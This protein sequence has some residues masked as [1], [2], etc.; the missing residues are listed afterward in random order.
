MKLH[1][2]LTTF[3]IASCDTVIPR[4]NPDYVDG[5]V[6]KEASERLAEDLR[7][8]S[9]IQELEASL[10]YVKIRLRIYDAKEDGT[11]DQD[12]AACKKYAEIVAR[13]FVHLSYSGVGSSPICQ[14]TGL[15]YDLF[16][17][18][19]GSVYETIAK[20]KTS[21]CPKA[22]VCPCSVDK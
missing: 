17:S 11:Y 6:A 21:C 10:N 15:Q 19:M 12:L 5:K 16:E 7:L 2:L 1:L 13:R 14:L 3:L 4:T 9:E 20:E 22:K 8:R 18:S